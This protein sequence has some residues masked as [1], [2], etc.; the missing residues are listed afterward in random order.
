MRQVG[1]ES[2]VMRGD[3]GR[4]TFNRERTAALQS[5]TRQPL[6]ARVDE[7][8]RR[9][10]TS[11]WV[12]NCDRR[13]EFRQVEATVFFWIFGSFLFGSFILIFFFP[14]R[15]NDGWAT[16]WMVDRAAPVSSSHSVC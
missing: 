16:E 5:E 12:T 9:A 4:P 2:R 14:V 1:R 8:A 10:I 13:S 6:Q 15:T 7:R 11:S 3:R